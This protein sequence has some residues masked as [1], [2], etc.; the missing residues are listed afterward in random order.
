[1]SELLLNL[2]DGGS[3]R[4]QALLQHPLEV[5]PVVF[6]VIPRKSYASDG[7]AG[8]KIH[9][10]DERRCSDCLVAVS[11]RRWYLVG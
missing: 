8:T 9:L 10:V 7:L 4:Q 6:L 5:A 1:M 3:S 2:D 11:Q